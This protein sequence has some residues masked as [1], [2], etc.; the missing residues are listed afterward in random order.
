M[1]LM[2]L[3]ATGFPVRCLENSQAGF[4]RRKTQMGLLKFQRVRKC[5]F[6]SSMSADAPSR[7]ATQGRD[8]SLQRL[9]VSLP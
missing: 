2:R 1:G 5:H 3:P 7:A 4:H 8:I 9:W 6:K